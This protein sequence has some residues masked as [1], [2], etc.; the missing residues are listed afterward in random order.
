MIKMFEDELKLF[1]KLPK[2]SRR[3]II[4]TPSRSLR[5]CIERNSLKGVEG[6]LA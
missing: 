3:F 1:R 5:T 6:V 4:S 2:G